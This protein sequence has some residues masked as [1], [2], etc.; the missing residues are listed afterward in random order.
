[1]FFLY[2]REFKHAKSMTMGSDCQQ[3]NGHYE[4][5]MQKQISLW[6]F[7]YLMSTIGV[8]DHTTQMPQ[9]SLIKVI[10]VLNHFII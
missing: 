4:P 1:M 8:F 5:T 6:I 10:L 2:V 7:P 3:K 9:V